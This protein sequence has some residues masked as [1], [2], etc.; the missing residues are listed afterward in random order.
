MTRKPKRPIYRRKRYYVLLLLLGAVYFLYHMLELQVSDGAL[1]AQLNQNGYQLEAKVGYFRSGERKLRYVEIGRDSLPLIV[2]LHG[3]PSSSA[4]WLSMMTD[5][6]LL[7]RAK[8][9]AVDRP[10]YGSSGIGLPEISVQ[11][12]AASVSRLLREK[13]REH[14]RIILH[15][16]SYGGTLAARLAMDYPDLVDGVLL[17]S[18]SVKPGSEK[19]FWI[20]Y[21]TSHW[22]LSWLMPGG[23]HTA[24]VEKLTHREQLEAMVDGWDRIDDP[25]IILHGTNDWLIY[26]DNA[27]F[28]CEELVNAPYV[29]HI[30]A[31]GRGHDL[32]WTEPELLRR[33]LLRLLRAAKEEAQSAVLSNR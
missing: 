18:A 27:Y 13:R 15:G 5:S 8:L 33:S 11:K 2:F 16:S 7:S 23:L 1:T 25:T 3:A 32:L 31:E 20:T 14:E 4:F 24:N 28:A 26:P 6:S 12:Q 22:S 17:Q 29:R 10:G 30:M 9:L 19:T 21:P